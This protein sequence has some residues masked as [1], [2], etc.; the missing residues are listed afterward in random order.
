MVLE[1][2]SRVLLTGAS[3]F[4]GNAIKFT[5][6]KHHHNV[7]TIGRSRDSDIS[8]DLNQDKLLELPS[9]DLLIHAAGLA[10]RVATNKRETKAFFNTN[11]EGTLR[12]LRALEQ[13]P[14]KQFIF[15]ST[16]AVYGVE[17]GNEIDENHSLNGFSPYARSKIQAEEAC[18]EWGL[19]HQVPVLILRFPL[20]SGPNPPGNLGAMARAIQKGLYV[21]PKEASGKKSMLGV[22]SVGQFLANLN[23]T[24]AGIYNLTDGC[25][26]SL[27]EIES[28]I[29]EQLHR[30]IRQVPLPFLKGAARIGD[31]WRGFPLNTSKLNKLTMDLTFNDDKA[32]RE[33]QW[34]PPPALNELTFS[35]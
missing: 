33:L 27:K 9:V 24:E 17:F 19:N 23:G 29:S 30:P 10:H 5:L 28:R 7:S 3:G 6:N 13:N 25:H 12:L 4:L 18:V 15:I 22:N 34:N 14:P 35:Q 20:L 2:T 31:L 11:Q 8:W 21:S 16:V 26:P 32:R 1:K